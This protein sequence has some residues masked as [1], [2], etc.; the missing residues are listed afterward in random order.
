VTCVW[1]GR[2]EVCLAL[3]KACYKEDRGSVSDV[4]RRVD[5]WEL[6]KRMLIQLKC[7]LEYDSSEEAIKLVALDATF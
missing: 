7:K 3:L 1:F 2:R 4:E 6:S 5:R